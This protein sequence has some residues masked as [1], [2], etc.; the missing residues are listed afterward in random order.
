VR[1]RS[2]FPRSCA[3]RFNSAYLGYY[4]VRAAR[5]WRAHDR[6]LRAWRW[7]SRSDRLALH[8]IEVNVQPTNRRSLALVA[9]LHFFC[10]G[11][12]R[13][14]V[15]IAGRWRD[16]VRFAMLAEDW[17]RLR[18]I[19]A[20][21]FERKPFNLTSAAPS[22]RC[23]ERRSDRDRMRGALAGA[24]APEGRRNSIWRRTPRKTS[25][26]DLV[27]GDR[28]DYRFESNEAGQVQHLVPRQRHGSWSR[29]VR[30]SLVARFGVF[31][32]QITVALLSDLGSRTPTGAL[33]DYHAHD[34]RR[35]AMI[36]DRALAVRPRRHAD[37]QLRGHC[38]IESVTRLSRLHAHMPSESH[39]QIDASARRCARS[40]ARLLDTGDPPALNRRSS[41]IANA[42]PI[43]AGEKTSSMTASPSCSPPSLRPDDGFSSARR[44]L[45][46][47]ARRIVTHFG[48]APCFRGVYGADL[49]GA[50]DD[51]AVLL[52]HAL[53]R[54]QLVAG[55]AI[56]IGDHVQRYTRGAMKTAYA[57]SACCGDMARVK[58]LPTRMRS[59]SIREASRAFGR[60]NRDPH[61]DNTR[62]SE[63]RIFVGP[64]L[65]DR[66][67]QDLP[68]RFSRPRR[69]AP[70]AAAARGNP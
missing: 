13:R 24:R 26:V 9:R 1:R 21:Q 42:L 31:A 44:N 70:R 52:R 66:S 15:K 68:R 40:F 22:R 53:D 55:D 47:F 4:A 10:E 12:S 18:K 36:A 7:T 32:V 43:S 41:T 64:A 58:S 2:T 3:T 17:D 35:L 38:D 69:P 27:S 61:C 33:V 37:G 45:R 62:R 57:P 8:R 39:P 16:H 50:F 67:E 14:Y 19:V 65:L 59:P 63:L 6:G 48:I 11:Y 56:M 23:V 29:I 30:D 51:K 5:R 46:Y 60:R 54:E 49:A 28:L 34:R 25:C 20:R